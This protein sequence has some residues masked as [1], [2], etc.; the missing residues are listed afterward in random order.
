MRNQ[1]FTTTLLVDQTPEEVFNAINNVRG[2]WSEEI[3]GNTNQVNDVFTYHYEDIHRCQIKLIEV[4]PYEKVVWLVIDNYFNFTKDKS[5]W[6]G[7]TISF[8]IS[9]KNNQTQ[10]RFTHLGL[11]PE[12]ECYTICRDAWSNYIHNSLRSLIMTGK[13]QPNS[14]GNPRTADEKKLSADRK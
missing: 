4:I 13:G 7:T 6:T 9:K 12:Y 3:E 2:W 10:I 8:E 1:D 14:T 11:V 5:E